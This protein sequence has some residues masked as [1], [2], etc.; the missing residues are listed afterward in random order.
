M[1]VVNLF[2]ARSTEPKELYEMDDPVGPKND[3]YID[4]AVKSATKYVVCAW[5]ANKLVGQ[6]GFKLANRLRKMGVTLKCM[7]KSVEGHP[8]H[9]LYLPGDQPLEAFSA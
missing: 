6:R 5:G 2:A 9:P 1:I 4:F 8:R 7:G 3:E